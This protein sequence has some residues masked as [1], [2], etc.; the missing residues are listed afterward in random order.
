MSKDNIANNGL[1]FP[2][3]EAPTGF[4]HGW[5]SA[6][7]ATFCGS[8]FY[9][10]EEGHRIVVSEVGIETKTQN[11]DWSLKNLWNDMIYVGLVQTFAGLATKGENQ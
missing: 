9:L 5:Y 7:Q 6:K 11:T 4:L 2:T 8:L 1:L 3:E 10:N